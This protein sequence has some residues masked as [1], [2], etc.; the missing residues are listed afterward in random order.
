MLATWVRRGDRARTLARVLARVLAPG[1]GGG[2]GPPRASPRWVA[3]AARRFP[4]SPA[5]VVVARGFAAPSSRDARSDRLDADIN[6]APD[7]RALM[8]V[9]LNEWD[10]LRPKHLADALRRLSRV[11]PWDRDAKSSGGFGDADFAPIVRRVEEIA[12]ARLDE[13]PG[14]TPS[15]AGH[16]EQPDIFAEEAFAVVAANALVNLGK[17]RAA[18][19]PTRVGSPGWRAWRAVLALPAAP[20]VAPYKPRNVMRLWYAMATAHDAAG[21]DAGREAA[22]PDAAW[23]S[24]DAMT[25]KNAKA[26]RHFNAQGVGIGV[27]SHAKTGKPIAPSTLRAFEV[28]VARGAF[29]HVA[30]VGQNVSNSLWGLAK[31]GH[32]VSRGILEHGA[33]GFPSPRSKFEDAVRRLAPG[34]RPQEIANTMYAYALMGTPPSATTWKTLEAEAR[35]RAGGHA[36]LDAHVPFESKGSFVRRRTERGL[37]GPQEMTNVWWAH[38]TLGMRPSQSALYAYDETTAQ[39]AFHMSA[40]DVS[41][42]AYS[43]AMLNVFLRPGAFDALEGAIARNGRHTAGQNLSL[44]LWAFADLAVRPG[45][46]AAAA[47][48]DA[49]ENRLHTLNP[50]NVNM[51][52]WAFAILGMTPPPGAWRAMT[53]GMEEVIETLK[54]HEVMNAVWAMAAAHVTGEKLPLTPAYA[55][56]WRRLC[57]IPL[58]GFARSESRAMTR[59]PGGFAKSDRAKIGIIH[60]ARLIH[61]RLFPPESAASVDIGAIMPSEM[62]LA[63]ARDFRAD[64]MDTTRSKMQDKIAETLS[65]IGIEFETEKRSADGNFS[66]DFYLPRYDVALEYDGPS[67]YYRAWRDEDRAFPR[68]VP[69]FPRDEDV[70]VMRVPLWT[71]GK[72]KT[73]KTILRDALLE[74]GQVSKVVTVHGH[75]AFWFENKRGRRR[76]FIENLLRRELGRPMTPGTPEWWFDET[77]ANAEGDGG[78]E[79]EVSDGVSDATS[80][81]TSVSLEDAAGGETSP[82]TSAEEVGR[83]V[84]GASRAELARRWIRSL[85]SKRRERLERRLE[86]AANEGEMWTLVAASAEGDVT[87]VRAELRREV[88]EARA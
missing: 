20:G 57:S 7:V 83:T 85:P 38:A 66:M 59:S 6:E 55:M 72:E 73:I 22:V 31:L 15:R 49:V 76:T 81:A 21:N 54:P 77:G 37:F 43:M 9:I 5:V 1:A 48:A 19:D 62:A 88:L 58:D 34:M 78:E 60:H 45:P 14:R 11:A 63:T 41:N 52:V 56:A 18:F 75:E 82:S 70:S 80:D 71:V 33:A 35:A 68:T 74:R 4:P 32:A 36:R 67:H 23:T 42:T 12:S 25:K 30:T 28:A 27:W 13:A 24:L 40:Q 29:D 51:C 87:R 64:V 86:R 84:G 8:R 61:E 46:D 26:G 3:P 39:T 2:T 16:R 10:S 50:Q 17:R 53:T 44:T 65:D 79:E 69:G 47:L